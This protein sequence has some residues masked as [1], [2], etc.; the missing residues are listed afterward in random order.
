MF[1]EK[2]AMAPCT[3]G[4]LAHGMA[5]GGHIHL[6]NYEFTGVGGLATTSTFSH[7][8]DLRIR[9]LDLWSMVDTLSKLSS[10]AASQSLPTYGGPVPSLITS[11]D[12]IFHLESQRPMDHG[13]IT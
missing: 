11:H 9:D 2:E 8:P 4:G 5:H 6:E 13:E 10:V 12:Q 7:V 1:V 3:N